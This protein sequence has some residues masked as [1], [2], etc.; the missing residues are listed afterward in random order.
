MS[1]ANEADDKNG[2]WVNGDNGSVELFP[3]TLFVSLLSSS[4][5]PNDD[6]ESRGGS[7]SNVAK[8]GVGGGTVG[9][10]LSDDDNDDGSCLTA[11]ELT[12]A[13][14]GVLFIGVFPVDD[15]FIGTPWVKHRRSNS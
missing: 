9:L 14:A 15:E 7:V 12:T 10:L 4:T 13:I 3:T 5:I 6:S 1:K 11:F 8:M 2:S